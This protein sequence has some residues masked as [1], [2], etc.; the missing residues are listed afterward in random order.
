MI[1]LVCDRYGWPLAFNLSPGRDA[2]SR[3]FIPTIETIP[4]PG[5]LGRPRTRCRYVVADKGYDSE[6]L[7]Q[8]L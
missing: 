3:H 5:S 7:R 8:V 6:A 1:H 2:D 4:W